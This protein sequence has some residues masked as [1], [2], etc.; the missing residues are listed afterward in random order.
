MR[1]SKHVL[2]FFVAACALTQLACVKRVKSTDLKSPYQHALEGYYRAIDQ[3]PPDFS[4]A[5]AAANEVVTKAPADLEARSL[6][7]QIYLQMLEPLDAKSREPLMKD[8]AKIVHSAGGPPTADWVQPRALVT[9]GD[10]LVL[11]GN[12][13][14]M[15]M[16]SAGGQFDRWDAFRAYE[17]F[18]AARSFYGRADALADAT[19]NNAS[20]GLLRE[21]ENARDGYTRA[22][23]GALN[24]LSF[25][26]PL[27]R[28]PP[29]TGRR[30]GLLAD[31][32]RVFDTGSI[33][34]AR[35]GVATL[36]VRNHEA[37]RRLYTQLAVA[38][39]AS[40]K[41]WCANHAADPTVV[42]DGQA[43]LTSWLDTRERALLHAQLE[44]LLN[45]KAKSDE[46]EA[47][48][49]EF[50]YTNSKLPDACKL[51]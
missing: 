8:L 14:N 35:P 2:I 42:K 47:Q 44:L 26:D 45:P 51:P 37:Q 5:L 36:E 29:T 4:A 30:Q 7:T 16:N 27:S 38:A 25:I 46:D 20:A 33:G 11:I 40:L 49:V 17:L 41:E 24:A 3:T 1:Y 50:A 28:L 6:R 48:A 23:E 21:G 32:E 13:L 34:P 22:T 31:A 15:R 9:G 18:D 19:K 39:R 43:L 10:L 12:S